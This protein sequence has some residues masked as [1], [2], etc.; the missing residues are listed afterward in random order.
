MNSGKFDKFSGAKL[1][2]FIFECIM[3]LFY[4]AF[5]FIFLFTSLL[6]NRIQTEFR[7]GMG[8]VLGLYGIYRVNAAYKKITQRNE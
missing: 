5:S 8:I 1:G 6:N 3:A 7:I 4:V 2:L